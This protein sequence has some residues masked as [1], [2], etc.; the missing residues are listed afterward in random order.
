MGLKA[1]DVMISPIKGEKVADPVFT[2]LDVCEQSN[3]D[4]CIKK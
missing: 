1:P 3:M 4:T 2:G